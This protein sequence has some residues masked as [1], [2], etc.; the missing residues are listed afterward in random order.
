MRRYVI[1]ITSNIAEG[2]GRST[3][4]DKNNFF[5]VS[6]GSVTEIQ[7]QLLVSSKD[8]KYINEKIFKDIA[9]RTVRMHK[10]I[11]GLIKNNKRVA[12]RK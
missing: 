4:K 11:N 2:F 1:S 9:D 8:L 7:N 6:L 10:L 3:P 5:Y 12:G